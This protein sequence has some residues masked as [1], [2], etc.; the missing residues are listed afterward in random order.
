M[1]KKMQVRISHFAEDKIE[2]FYFFAMQRH[3][4][5]SRETVIAKLARMREKL[6]VLGVFP[7]GFALAENQEWREKGYRE[8]NVEKF[9]FAYQELIDPKTNEHFVY[10]FD[11]IYET[12]Y[13]L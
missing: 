7:N 10:I 13:Q 1:Q 4:S 5:L 3:P 8:L 12:E 2:Q 11:V 9:R 6:E